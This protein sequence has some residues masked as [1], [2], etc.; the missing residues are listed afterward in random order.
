MSIAEEEE[1]EFDTM[2]EVVEELEFDDPRK[3][4]ED[5]AELGEGATIEFAESGDGIDDPNG[6]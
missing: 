4:T 3:A 2:T 1:F 5:A 6:E